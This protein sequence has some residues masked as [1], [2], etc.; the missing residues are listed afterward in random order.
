M[1]GNLAEMS[2][3]PMYISLPS[4]GGRTLQKELR[5][6]WSHIKTIIPDVGNFTKNSKFQRLKSSYSGT[7][8]ELYLNQVIP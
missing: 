4:G 3:K 8:V 7:R 2:D 5:E 6:L 1:L